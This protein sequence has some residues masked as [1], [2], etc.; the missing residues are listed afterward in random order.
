MPLERGRKKTGGR[1]KGSLNKRPLAL[2]DKA[3]ELGIDPFEILLLFAD[4]RWKELG[5]PARTVTKCSPDGTPYEEY[6]ISP[7]LRQRSASDAAQYVHA[8]RKAIEL[9]GE[10]GEAIQIEDRRKQT[11]QMLSDPET[12]AAARLLEKK[13]SESKS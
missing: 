2:L 9:S 5:Y 6:I 12:L 3:N 7:E 8:K 4:E 10:N 11:I 13:L 1:K